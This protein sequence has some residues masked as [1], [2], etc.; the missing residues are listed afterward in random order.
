MNDENLSTVIIANRNQIAQAKA[1]FNDRFPIIHG[2]DS[3]NT[4]I[5]IRE[6]Y[7]SGT[8]RFIVLGGDGTVNCLANALIEDAQSLDPSIKIIVLGGGT[9]NDYIRSLRQRFGLDPFQKVIPSNQINNCQFVSVDVGRITFDTFS[10]IDP[11]IFINMFGPGFSGKVVQ[12]RNRLPALVPKSLSYSLPSAKSLLFF[13]PRLI[14]LS[15]DGLPKFEGKSFGLFISKGR[16]A[17][18]GMVLG[19]NAILDDGLFDITLIP[20]LSFFKLAKGL[21][22]AVGGRPPEIPGALRFKASSLEIESLECPWEVETDGEY[23][24]QASSMTVELL[25]KM[26]SMSTAAQA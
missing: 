4:K 5:L 22:L 17:G 19:A 1:I 20:Q 11:K 15:S 13:K 26:L 12:D 14:K 8:R 9:G 2:Q 6:S 24:G 16:F 18:G 3:Q 25:P 10:S 7:K 21:S 23:L